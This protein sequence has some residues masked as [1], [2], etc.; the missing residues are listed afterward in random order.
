VKKSLTF[1]LGIILGKPFLR[2]LYNTNRWDVK[3]E[4]HVKDALSSGKSVIVASW[5]D[6]LLIPF[7]H[8][9]GQN[10]YGIAG[11]HGD[12]EI[13]SRIG[14]NLGWQI[15]R[16]SS[17]ERGKEVYDELLDVLKQ[18]GNLV[19]ITPDGPK[20]PAKIPKA[21]TIRAA[22]KTGAVIVPMAG[23][24][25]KSWE[26]TNWDTFLVAMPFG[27]ISAVYGEPLEFQLEESFEDCADRLTHALNKVEKLA[28]ENVAAY[29]V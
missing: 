1:W 18:P 25:T 2:F 9:S 5:H 26:F 6:C 19:A 15:L 17:T 27:T 4:H 12:A 14:E 11:T 7:M 29:S 3:G 24:S 13:I 16:G 22:Q 8:L 10:H 21:G 20:G 28:E 23:R